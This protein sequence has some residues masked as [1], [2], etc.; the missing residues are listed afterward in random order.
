MILTPDN[1]VH[2]L[3]DQNLISTE[4]VVDGDLMVVDMT[5][6][7]R[8]FKILRKTDKGLFVKQ[9]RNFDVQSVASLVREAQSY[10]LVATDPAFRAISGL[11]PSSLHFDTARNILVLGLL[12]ESE[13][14][15]EMY[16]RLGE[17]PSYIAATLG[18]S[19]GC[20]HREVGRTLEQVRHTKL[21]PETLP[22]MLTI[23]QEY[24]QQAKTVDEN[25]CRFYSIIAKY[26]EFL[27]SIHRLRTG[28]KADSLI[29]GDMKWDNCMVYKDEAASSDELALKIVDWEL[30][31]LGDSAW[32]AGAVFQTFL[33]LWVMSLPEVNGE[34]EQQRDKYSIEKMQPAIR[35]FWDAYTG[36]MSIEKKA[37][38]LL[39]KK[40]VEYAA[41][42]IIQ[43]GYETLFHSRQMSNAIVYLLQ[44]SLNILKDPDEAITA[45]LGL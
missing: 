36:T 16:R 25:H 44:L 20:Y 29:H 12:P 5:R 30:A 28:W 22:W 3:T 34:E 17:F 33:S 23:T 13:N 15:S 1:I 7:N 8:N 38:T 32:D 11:M 35:S 40:C 39:L 24:I 14:L 43:T 4:S 10:R 42:R 31:D 21:F 45:L 6:R 41:V 9:P 18:R 26:P 2:Y 27:D 19:L 37:R